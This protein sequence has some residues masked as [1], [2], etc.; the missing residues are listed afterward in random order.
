MPGGERGCSFPGGLVEQRVH[1]RVQKRFEE[2][3]IW[4]VACNHTASFHKRRA[5]PH[6][7]L[8]G[9][10]A[11]ARLLGRPKLPATVGSYL[12]LY[13]PFFNELAEYC[14]T[15]DSRMLDKALFSYGALDERTFS[16]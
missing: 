9:K 5:V 7:R 16:N 2:E 15:N 4:A 12:D 13:I 10:T 8:A 11:L 3:T 6:L 14:E 1:G